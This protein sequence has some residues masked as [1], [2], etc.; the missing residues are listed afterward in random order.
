[1]MS[2]EPVVA[3]GVGLPLLGAQ[4]RAAQWSGIGLVVVACAGVARGSRADA[5]AIGRMPKWR[6]P[7][8]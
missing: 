8:L 2:S 6:C 7:A 3:A 1:M 5:V 4:M